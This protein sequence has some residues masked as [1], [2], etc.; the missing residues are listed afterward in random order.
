MYLNFKEIKEKLTVEEVLN[1]LNINH[2]KFK[3]ESYSGFCPIHKGKN[4]NAFHFNKSKKI[5]N[6]FTKCGG[7]NILDFIMK[8]KNISIYEAGLIGLNIVKE[9]K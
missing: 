1:E 5:F 3:S 6:C 7:G 2:L 8:Y 9:K 4:K